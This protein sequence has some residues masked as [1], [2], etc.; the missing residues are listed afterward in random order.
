MAASPPTTAT[1]ACKYRTPLFLTMIVAGLVGNYFNF[2]IFLNIYFL[3]GSIFALLAL[4][5]FGLGRG[6]LAAA[7]ISSYT[8]ILWNH[9]YSLIIMTAE[10]AVVGVL[11]GHRRIGLVLADI[12][13]WLIVGMPLGYLF[14][15]VIMHAPPSNAYIVIIKEA[16][17]GIA[18]ALIARLLFTMYMHRSRTALI[19]YREIVCNLLAFFVLFPSLIMLAVD[20][21]TDF[22]E[23]D[24]HVR[25]TL[26]QDSQSVDQRLEA[27]VKNREAAIVTLA[28]MAS[29][30]SPEQMQPFLEQAKKADVNFYYIGLRNRD[31]TTTAIFPLVDELGQDGVGK[32]YAD[33]SYVQTLKRSLKPML[34]EVV[35]SRV[36]IPVPRVLM[37]APIV[38]RGHYGGFA[39]GAMNL[40]QI[41]EYLNKKTD[42]DATHYT[43]LDRNG[44]VIM[45]N[46][47]DQKVLSPF[48]H[49]KGTFIRLEKGVSQWVP[50]VPSNTLLSGRWQKS[51]Y[52]AETT[53]GNFSEW[54]LILEQPVAP[55]QNALSK[56]YTNKLSLIFLIL[57]LSLALAELLSRNIVSTLRQLRTLT[58]ELPGK[59]ATDGDGIEW[60]DSGITEAN[61]LINNFRQM[62]NSLVG[63]FY[64]IRQINE[65][66]EQRVEARTA[67]LL[68]REEAYRTVAD[69]TYDWE[70]WMAPDGTLRYISPSCERHTGYYREEFQKDPALMERITHPDDRIQFS[71]H[72]DVAPDAAEKT[73]QHQ[74]DFRIITRSGE[75]RWF[76][77]VC[78][79]VY[80]NAGKY[81]GQ[82]ATN[83]D[84]TQRKQAE[85]SLRKSEALYHSLVETS[86]DLIWQCDSEGRFT[87]LNLAWEQVLG[88]ELDEMLGRKFSD[89]QTPESAERS[90]IE[91]RHILEGNSVTGFETVHRGK[92]GNELDL[93]FNALFMSDENG[94]IIG[95]SGTAYDISGRKQMEMELRQ[96]KAAAEAAT[97][98]KSRFLATMSHEI[99]TPMNGV[100]GMIEL[101]QHTRLTHEQYGFAESAKKSGIELVHLLND[102]LDLSKIEAD[103]IELEVFDFDLQTVVA[104]VINLMS[105]QALEKG[106][107]LTSSIDDDVPVVLKGDPGRLRQI[108]TNLVGN[109]IKFTPKGSVTLQT[110]KD[111]ETEHSIT[112]RFLIRDSGIGIAADKLEHVFDPFTQ[113]DSSTTRTYGGTGLGLAI[114]KQLAA[115]MNG[116]IGAESMEGH[117]STFWFTAKMEKQRS[118][119]LQLDLLTSSNGSGKDDV[120]FDI[121]GSIPVNHPVAVGDETGIT[122][123]LL[124]DDDPTARKIVPQLLKSYGY[125]VDVAVDGKEALQALE[126]HDY[127]LVL[128][129]CMMP[130]M[131]GFEVTAVIRDPASAVRRHDL[132]VIA[133]TGNAMKRDRDRCI[134]AGMNDHLPKP[135]MLPDLLTMLEK[136]IK[137]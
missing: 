89:F 133:L 77:H 80:D 126:M 95:A 79:P 61:H 117:G 114:C 75:E 90:R 93:V 6:I 67:E 62:A 71:S 122:R 64:E 94:N 18:N 101:L 112:L 17:N 108:I 11:M 91:F 92:S 3:F 130:E 134:A 82:R 68:E 105:L 109:A 41:Q 123:I 57:L 121:H 65:S 35:M 60:P 129:D 52:V 24:R 55:Y 137:Q 4:Q 87:Y 106:I 128:M 118:D 32:N 88:Y 66:L 120:T 96:A 85:V 58:F 49:G 33:R 111:S 15:H 81:L 8:Y 83:R 45:T 44:I 116:S 73:N 103:K 99:R 135:L 50:D 104:D 5:L 16:V 125:L 84:I 10:V 37:L 27:W 74:M 36:G 42:H 107:K 56:R 131:N 127:A 38:T 98:A 78:Q 12:L 119:G 47:A 30:K 31:A 23:T 70:Y 13:Y 2:P 29:S 63:Q 43:L 51:F 21:R 9:P 54:R 7:I 136:W 113:A 25:S 48:V 86:Q 14:Y 76:S 124:T 59:L 69:Y 28:E 19:S 40:A 26:L 102:I 1:V 132:P 20:S 97:I 115:L 72:L 22:N 110:R 39:V 34:S 46:C 53:I 100:I